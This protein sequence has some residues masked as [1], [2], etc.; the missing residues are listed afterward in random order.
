MPETPAITTP[1]IL[2]TE[3]ALE[4]NFG[5]GDM[6]RLWQVLQ[7]VKIPAGLDLLLAFAD[8]NYNVLDDNQ[9]P[10]IHMLIEPYAHETEDEGTK[11]F[12]EGQGRGTC[13]GHMLISEYLLRRLQ[14][15]KSEQYDWL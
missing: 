15:H 4:N 11:Y 9:K 12:V 1:K 8:I 2:S 6:D 14:L 10:L 5:W 13:F 7:S 3:S